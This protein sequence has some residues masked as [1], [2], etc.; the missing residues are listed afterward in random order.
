MNNVQKHSR[1]RQLYKNTSMYCTLEKKPFACKH[2][3]HGFITK[4]RLK[5]H[6]IVCE[7]KSDSDSDWSYILLLEIH[8]LSILLLNNRLYSRFQ[9]EHVFNNLQFIFSGQYTIFRIIL[10][11]AYF[12]QVSM[13]TENRE[14]TNN[15]DI[16][17][18]AEMKNGNNCFPF[19]DPKVESDIRIKIEADSVATTR[20]DAGFKIKIEPAHWRIW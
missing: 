20:V 13:K 16:P 7:P 15:I 4:D 18:K 19:E 3:K 2:C 17:G 5:K 11:K 6:E 12:H 1:N 9:V 8:L 14:S 10:R